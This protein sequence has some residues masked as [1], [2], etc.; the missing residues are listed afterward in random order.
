VAAGALVWATRRSTGG[1]SGA[2]AVEPAVID[3]E[4]PL[5]VEMGELEPALESR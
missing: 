5:E 1:A 2:E 4:A 3:V